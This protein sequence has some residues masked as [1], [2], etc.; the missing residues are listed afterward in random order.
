MKGFYA[1]CHGRGEKKE[2][3]ERNKRGS[4]RPL[5]VSLDLQQRTQSYFA[6]FSR[7]QNGKI[8]LTLSVFR[9]IQGGGKMLGP[10]GDHTDTPFA[11]DNMVKFFF[12]AWK[13]ELR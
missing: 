3:R 4:R 12:S 5:R 2:I 1:Y 10:G 7:A 8:T 13:S 9:S 6:L 11:P